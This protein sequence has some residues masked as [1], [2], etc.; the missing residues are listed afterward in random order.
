MT[1]IVMT[2]CATV[3]AAYGI[4]AIQHGV[5][6]PVTSFDIMKAKV[7]CEPGRTHRIWSRF[8]FTGNAIVDVECDDGVSHRIGDFRA[9]NGW[10]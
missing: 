9:E 7:A 6:I 8:T 2:I 3:L 10:E 5:A 4:F 1:K